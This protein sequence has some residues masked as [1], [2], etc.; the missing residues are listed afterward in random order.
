LSRSTF[1]SR[2]RA[3]DRHAKGGRV[4]RTR[5][6]RRDAVA[7]F[8]LIEVL[9]ALSVVAVSLAAIGSLIATTVR[10]VRTLDRRVALVE[11]TRAVMSGLPGRDE[12]ASGNM[13]G[14]LAGHR[15]RVDVSP[16]IVEEVDPSGAGPW[17]PY[18][19]VVRVQGASGSLLQ[20]NTVRLRRNAPP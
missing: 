14:A 18:S 9:V 8:T 11:T 15:W 2:R 12:L 1:S 20:V 6:T 16:I 19:V 3:K 17:T 4:E 5:A 7:G 13:S 10:G